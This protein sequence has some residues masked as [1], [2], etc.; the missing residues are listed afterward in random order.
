MGVNKKTFEV[1]Y[2]AK[3][4]LPVFIPHRYMNVTFKTTVLAE[5]DDEAEQNFNKYYPC[6]Q[7]VSIMQREDCK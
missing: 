1:E 2:K 5:S 7:V 3:R 6:A 4:N